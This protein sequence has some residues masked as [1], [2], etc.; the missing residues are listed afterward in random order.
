LALP[1][2]AHT[3]QVTWRPP[4][5]RLI[6]GP[7]AW[8]ILFDWPITYFGMFFNDVLGNI[9]AASGKNAAHFIFIV[10]AYLDPPA[11]KNASNI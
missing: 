4:P 7:S 1:P 9:N 8:S 3:A 2:A 5:H 11:E 6:W 10:R